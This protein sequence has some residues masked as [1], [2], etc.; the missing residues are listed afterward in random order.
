MNQ[1]ACPKCKG[2]KTVLKIFEM[3][4][5]SKRGWFPVKCPYCNGRGYVSKAEAKKYMQEKGQKNVKR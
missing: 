1:V 2:L 3:C 4:N 5:G